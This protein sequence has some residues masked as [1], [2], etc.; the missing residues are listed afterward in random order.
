MI[1]ALDL[2]RSA[3]VD[4]RVTKKMLVEHG[5]VTPADASAFAGIE[6][7]AFG[8]VAI[9]FFLNTGCYLQLGRRKY[10]I[11]KN[12]NGRWRLYRNSN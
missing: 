6:F 4:Q 7:G 9:G 5:A 3:R 2:P 10:H 11:N 12:G 8:C 1:A